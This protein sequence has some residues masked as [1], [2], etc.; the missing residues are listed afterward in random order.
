M[1]DGDDDVGLDQQV[2]GFLHFCCL[3]LAGHLR[4]HKLLRGLLCR[5]PHGHPQQLRVY[6]FLVFGEVGFITSNEIV[7]YFLAL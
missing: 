2:E 1:G 5:T 4:I 7:L 6:L 3:I